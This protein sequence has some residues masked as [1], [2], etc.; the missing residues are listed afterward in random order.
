[1]LAKAAAAI[2]ELVGGRLDLGI[3]AGE[4]EMEHQDVQYS[5]LATS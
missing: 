3:G 2:S 5:F 4:N 1:V